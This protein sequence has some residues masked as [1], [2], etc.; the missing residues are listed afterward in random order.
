MT[1]NPSRLIIDTDT[2]GDDTRAI[3]L[4]ALSDRVSLEGLT[5]SAGNV[6]FEDQVENAKYTLDLVDHEATVYEGARRPLVKDHEFADE[7]HGEGGLGGDIHPETGIESGDRHAV[8]YIVDMAREHP[9][10]V[11]LACIAPL[12]NIALAIRR[13]PRLPE[14]LDSV[15]VMG[16]NV[17]WSGN[18]TP[19]AEFNFWVDPEAAKIVLEEMDVTLFDWGLTVRDTYFGPDIIEE[20]ESGPQTDLVEFYLETAKVDREYNRKYRGGEAIS[21]PDSALLAGLIEPDL[22]EET[23]TH[24]VTVDEREGLTRGY[25]SVDWGEWELAEPRTTVVESFD[26]DGFRR[27]MLGLVR[28][29]DPHAQ[30]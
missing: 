16:G 25:T 1:S 27:M 18:I 13:E 22:V 17:N 5:I 11:T 10:E 3:L 15:Y 30:L 4:G 14:L 6:G 28:D 9:G 23:A 26:T 21:H 7:V 29:S 24:Y 8:D 19:A 12:T 20:F 2:A